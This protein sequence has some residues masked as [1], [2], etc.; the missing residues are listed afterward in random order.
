MPDS[1]QKL[2]TSVRQ[3]YEELEKNQRLV[4]A[5]V[6][7]FWSK[8]EKQGTAVGPRVYWLPRKLSLAPPKM[9]SYP[10]ILPGP[11]GANRTVH[12]DAIND[13]RSRVEVWLYAEQGRPD[14]DIEDLFDLYALALKDV[15]VV[16][17]EYSFEADWQEQDA[18]SVATDCMRGSLT[19]INPLIVQKPV[20]PM[21]DDNVSLRDT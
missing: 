11:N 12:L 4:H 1:R 10:A 6:R 2:Y 20:A 3:V 15:L 18:L 17:S 8:V 19:F 7:H 21:A 5:G 9:T 16:E 13:K 14:I